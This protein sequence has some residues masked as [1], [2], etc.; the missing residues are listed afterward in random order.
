MSVRIHIVLDDDLGARLKALAER[1]DRALSRQVAY[2]LRQIMGE[3]RPTSY[4][5]LVTSAS[6]EPPMPVE[7][8]YDVQPEDMPP[9][10]QVGDWWRQ[11]R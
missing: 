6:P 8:P 4:D 5:G 3:P 1:E 10:E 2:M 11:Q 7:E 9:P